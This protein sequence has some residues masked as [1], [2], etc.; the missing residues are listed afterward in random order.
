MS[1]MKLGIRGPGHPREPTSF[2]EERP[3]YNSQ[4]CLTRGY[5]VGFLGSG[6]SRIK[7]GIWG[8][9]PPPGPTSFQEERPEYTSQGCLTRGSPIGFLRSGVSLMKLGIRDLQLKQGRDS[10]LKVYTRGGAVEP[11]HTGHLVLRGKWPL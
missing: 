7:L 10:G 3:E 6:V 8:P 9:R 5:P 1:L 4:Q 2:Q 11:L